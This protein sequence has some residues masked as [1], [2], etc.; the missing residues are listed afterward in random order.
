M[1]SIESDCHEFESGATGEDKSRVKGE[2]PADRPRRRYRESQTGELE[3][4]TSFGKS[5]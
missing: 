5:L 3:A 2:T 1:T 4:Y